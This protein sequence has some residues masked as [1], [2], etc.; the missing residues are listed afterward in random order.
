MLSAGSDVDAVNLTDRLGVR[1]ASAKDGMDAF[2][3]RMERT[4]PN[5]LERL[6][7]LSGELVGV[8]DCRSIN[9]L[10]FFSDFDLFPLT[11]CK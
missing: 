3:L 2:F 10:L 4:E 1:P 9:E 7:D 5:V 8:V 6:S 11:G